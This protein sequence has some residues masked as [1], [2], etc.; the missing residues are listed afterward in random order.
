MMTKVKNVDDLCKYTGQFGVYQAC[1]FVCLMGLNFYLYDSLTI[2]FVGA[3]MP[4]WCRVDELANLSFSQQQNIAIPYSEPGSAE[5]SSCQVYSLNYSA[6]SNEELLSWN[7]TLMVNENTPVGDC[8]QW[9]YDQTTF[10]STIVSRVI[11]KFI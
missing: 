9:T 10:V 5:Y 4:H 1:I 7:R 6:Y 8:N 2:I 3:D 11:I